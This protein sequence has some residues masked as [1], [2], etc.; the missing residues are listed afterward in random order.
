MGSAI[1]TCFGYWLIASGLLTGVVFFGKSSLQFPQI[2]SMVVSSMNWWR[3]V[4]NHNGYRFFCPAG[5]CY[6]VDLL[7][8]LL[9]LTRA[10]KGIR[11][12]VLRAMV[13]DMRSCVRKNGSFVCTDQS[14][15]PGLNLI[16]FFR[17]SWCGRT[18]LAKPRDSLDRLHL[19]HSTC[20]SFFTFTLH[21][22]MLL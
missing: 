3:L 22:T 4:V 16:W 6:D 2:S 14:S 15:L 7:C 19:L 12:L 10:R 11:E 17:H 18:F 8:S 5:V 1:I 9:L 20:F 13:F 21:I